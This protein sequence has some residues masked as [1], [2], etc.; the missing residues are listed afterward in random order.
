MSIILPN[1]GF[2][3]P[4]IRKKR[5]ASPFFQEK[6]MANKPMRWKSFHWLLELYDYLFSISFF[7]GFYCIM[8]IMWF[9][10][11]WFQ[12]ALNQKQYVRSNSKQWKKTKQT[13][14]K[15][16]QQF[17]P[18]ASF[19]HRIAGIVLILTPQKHLMANAGAVITKPTLIKPAILH[20]AISTVNPYWAS[21]STFAC[22]TV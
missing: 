11:E 9:N 16:A 22:H 7:N 19:A 6:G 18:N 13:K 15:S 21:K 14:L 20:V 10:D 2:V 8:L 5:D 4:K 3:N 17:S 12:G 1:I